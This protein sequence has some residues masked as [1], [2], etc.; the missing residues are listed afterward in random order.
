MVSVVE[1]IVNFQVSINKSN[2][3]RYKRMHPNCP[4]FINLEMIFFR[5]ICVRKCTKKYCIIL[6]LKV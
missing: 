3:E 4:H 2:I 6:Q 1:V 5:N